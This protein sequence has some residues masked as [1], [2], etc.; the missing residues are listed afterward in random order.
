[1]VGFYVLLTAIV[2]IGGRSQGVGEAASNVLLQAGFAMV[3]LVVLIVLAS[4]GTV[5]RRIGLQYTR[6][7]AAIMIAFI[8]GSLAASSVGVIPL[9]SL[10]FGISVL[11]F[12]TACK[13][14]WLTYRPATRRTLLLVAASLFGVCAWQFAQ[15]G[16]ATG[17]YVGGMS[18]NHFAGIAAAAAFLTVGQ[19]IQL[20]LTAFG[21]A[22]AVALIVDSRG[23]LVVLGVYLLMGEAWVF[24]RRRFMSMGKA[25]PT[26]ASCAAL[27]AGGIAWAWVAGGGVGRRLLDEVFQLQDQER[28]LSSGF[29]G[30]TG[31]WQPAWEDI[32]Q[33]PFLGY[34]LR[35][36][37]YAPTMETSHMAYLDLVRDVGFPL[38]LLFMIFMMLAVL[39]PR[40]RIG[41]GAPREQPTMYS[42]R[43]AMAVTALLVNAIFEIHLLNLGFPTALVL[44]F[45]LSR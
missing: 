7:T 18:P 33:R 44:M 16:L 38:A 25:I 19:R 8:A 39:F 15:F 23:T 26:L 17:R 2:K 6:G 20:R 12:F 36:S 11:V 24:F 1:M 9:Q 32:G 30:R 43:H 40:I 28:G 45:L 22:T 29:S 42:W 21:F 10:I 41:D 35:A 14:V 34:G 3:G 4:D 31:L 5:R 13:I 37:T 27:A